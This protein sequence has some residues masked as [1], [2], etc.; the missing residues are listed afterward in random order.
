MVAKKTQVV[1]SNLFVLAREISDLIPKIISALRSFPIFLNLDFS[2][3][4]DRY[5]G[6]DVEILYQCTKR[7]N[8]TP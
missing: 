1:S 5:Q 6:K 2:Q 4:L 8:K 3:L 7:F